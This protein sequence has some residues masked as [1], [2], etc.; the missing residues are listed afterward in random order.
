MNIKS[1]DGTIFR[2]TREQG[3]THSETRN[4]KRKEPR[5]PVDSLEVTNYFSFSC[6]PLLFY[7]S[8]RYEDTHDD[9]VFE[10]FLDRYEMMYLSLDASSNKI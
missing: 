2:H 8:R 1:R 3:V 7:R 6:A 9:N 5:T 4:G 10:T